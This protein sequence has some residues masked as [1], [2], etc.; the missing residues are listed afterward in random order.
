MGTPALFILDA[1]NQ[2]KEFKNK[3]KLFKKRHN[4]NVFIEN[5][6]YKEALRWRVCVLH[7]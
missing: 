1:Y 5:F 4:K 7:S 3:N 6:T 2:A